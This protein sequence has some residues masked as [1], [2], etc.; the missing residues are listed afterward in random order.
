MAL[1]SCLY[2]L[3]LVGQTF[4]RAADHLNSVGMFSDEDILYLRIPVLGH[5]FGRQMAAGA[6]LNLCYSRAHLPA[7]RRSKGCSVALIH[8]QE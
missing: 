7:C 8:V 6:H 1:S 4:R 3:S 2:F 5:S